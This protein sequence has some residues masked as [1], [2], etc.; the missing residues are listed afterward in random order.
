MVS[1]W[2][3]LYLCCKWETLSHSQIT[4]FPGLK[5]WRV[6]FLKWEQNCICCDCSSVI[7]GLYFSACYSVIPRSKRKRLGKLN[8]AETA[9]TK[10]LPWLSSLTLLKG[11]TAKEFLR[12]TSRGYSRRKP[13]IK[14]Q[15]SGLS[16]SKLRATFWF[17]CKSGKLHRL[18]KALEGLGKR[19][20][21]ILWPP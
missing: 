8:G 10:E 16:L 6:H 5:S 1:L 3:V 4:G 14:P 13:F 7:S 11:I 12:D 20:S 9:P 17:F 18:L 21:L 2:A 19:H 15:Y